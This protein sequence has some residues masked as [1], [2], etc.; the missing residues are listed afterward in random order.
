MHY[1]VQY[2]C[3][4]TMTDIVLDDVVLLFI[5]IVNVLILL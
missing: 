1:I 2:F 5:F 4:I 3:S